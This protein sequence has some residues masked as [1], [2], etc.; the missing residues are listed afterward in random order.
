MFFEVFEEFYPYPS[1]FL[2]QGEDVFDNI[3][4]KEAL[5]KLVQLKTRQGCSSVHPH[6]LC[7]LMHIKAYGRKVLD[8]LPRCEDCH[9]LEE[10][11]T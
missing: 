2:Y 10:L 1:F 3:F 9:A 5:D 7:K 4:D 11:R 8:T 6:F